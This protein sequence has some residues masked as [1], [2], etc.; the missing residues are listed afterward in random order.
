MQFLYENNL[1]ST[2]MHKFCIYDSY[3]ITGGLKC[4]IYFLSWKCNKSFIVN[5]TINPF[6]GGGE[7]QKSN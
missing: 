6:F 5:G 3:S 4:L 7:R 2:L 1:R